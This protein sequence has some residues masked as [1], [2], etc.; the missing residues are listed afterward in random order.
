M[1]DA[2]FTNFA[3]STIEEFFDVG[4]LTL[5][6]NSDDVSKFP[7][8]GVGDYYFLTIFDGENE[9]EIVKVTG[10]ASEVLTVVRAQE[11]T[12]SGAW[13]VGA[14]VRLALTAAQAQDS[15]QSIAD[16]ESRI[17]VLEGTTATAISGNFLFCHG[18]LGGL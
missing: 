7:T 14:Y 12:N 9:P 4:D 8:L 18:F 6:I 2:L 16:H 1:T 17:A 10:A 3:E 11:S 13:D 5:T 15:L